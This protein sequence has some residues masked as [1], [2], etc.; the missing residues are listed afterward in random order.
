MVNGLVTARGHA[1]FGVLWTIAM[2]AIVVG[3][4]GVGGL[5][6]AP[7][8]LLVVPFA[9]TRITFRRTAKR[10]VPIYFTR[11]LWGRKSSY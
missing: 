10:S 3:M 9:A 2:L 8:L 4:S 11:M 1:A 6:F 5:V 7:W